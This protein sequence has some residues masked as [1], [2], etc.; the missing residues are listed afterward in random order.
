MIK[1]NTLNLKAHMT[2]QIHSI[3]GGNTAAKQA[4]E[5]FTRTQKL[6]LFTQRFE[7]VEH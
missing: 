4:A 3:E 1:I 6:K 7:V 2:K 5:S